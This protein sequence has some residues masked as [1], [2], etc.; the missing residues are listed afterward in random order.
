MEEQNETIRVPLARTAREGTTSASLAKSRI[1][2]MLGGFHYDVV[3][4]DWEGCTYRH[5]GAECHWCGRPLH[6]KLHTPRA[7]RAIADRDG[8]RV[9]EHF[10]NGDID[11]EGNL[12]IFAHLR[13]HAGMRLS[14]T[15]FVK[16]IL[17]ALT[18]QDVKKSRVNVKSHYDIPQEVLDVYLDKVYKS[19]SCAMFEDPEKMDI[20]TMVRAGNGEEDDFDSLEKAQWRKFKDAVDFLSPRSGDT[21]LDVGCGYGGQLLVALESHPFRKVVGWTHSENQAS[22]GKKSLQHIDEEHWEL[23]EGDYRLDER[24]YDHITS[25]GMISH[26]GP[27]GLVPYVRNIRRR[28]KKGGRYVHHAIMSSYTGKA[29]NSYIGPMLNKAYVWPGFHWFTI[30]DHLKAL[31]ENGFYIHRAVNL[32]SHYEKTIAAWYERMMSE[33]G[34]MVEKLGQPTFRAWQQYLAGA[35]GAM[36]LEMKGIQVFRVYCEAT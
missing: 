2:E 26:V 16:K 30:G 21:L 4:T 23:N 20:P 31:E 11:L 3:V 19:Y 22:V 35:C 29:L 9:M 27:R 7:G 10:F 17:R 34:L 15:V 12:Y 18:F 32:A 1:L 24:V 5:D 14:K 6:V 8:F 25:T 13:T 28:I 36:S 33:S